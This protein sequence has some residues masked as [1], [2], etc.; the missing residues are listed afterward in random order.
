MIGDAKKK[1]MNGLAPPNS[2]GGP[3]ASLGGPVA[4]FPSLPA[5]VPQDGNG[6]AFDYQQNAIKRRRVDQAPVVPISSAVA[7]STKQLAA[8]AAEAMQQQGKGRKKSQAQIDR[9]RERNRIL[10]RRTRLR[11]KFFFESLQN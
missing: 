10:A 2:L 6:M 1:H 11:K 7:T 9:R 8:A 3:V 4:P 5:Q